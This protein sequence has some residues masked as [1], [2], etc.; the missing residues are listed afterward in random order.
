MPHLLLRTLRTEQSAEHCGVPYSIER[1]DQGQ[2]IKKQG[3]RSVQCREVLTSFGFR[4]L[5]RPRRCPAPCL[6]R[7]SI[8]NSF[9]A[10]S[11]EETRL[12]YASYCDPPQTA[13]AARFGGRLA[14]RCRQLVGM[15]GA[16]ISGRTLSFQHTR[17]LYRFTIRVGCLA[18]ATINLFVLSFSKIYPGTNWPGTRVVA[19]WPLEQEHSVSVALKVNSCPRALSSRLQL[20]RDSGHVCRT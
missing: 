19:K 9:P 13:S 20:K 14:V 10:V 4:V 15:S 2:I 8:S 16:E 11:C 12:L 5:L 1:S 7:C 17:S 6:S 3:M 18:G